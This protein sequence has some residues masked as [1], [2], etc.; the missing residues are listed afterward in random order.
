MVQAVTE[1]TIQQFLYSVCN[2][3]VKVHI[4]EGTICCFDHTL[5]KNKIILV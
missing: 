5:S 1:N 3:N 2:N 4:Y